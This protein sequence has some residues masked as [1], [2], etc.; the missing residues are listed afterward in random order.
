MGPIPALLLTIAIIFALKYPL[1]RD[2][3]T[4]VVAELEARRAKA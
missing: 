4:K 1:D 2:G 3:Y